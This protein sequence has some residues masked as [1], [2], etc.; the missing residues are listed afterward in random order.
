MIEYFYSKCSIG[1]AELDLEQIPFLLDQNNRLQLISKIYFPAET[2]GDSGTSDS[3]D[4]F[5]NKIIFNW[6][7]EKAQRGIK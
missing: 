6:L 3:N 5:V 1:G 2:I 7:N 4:L